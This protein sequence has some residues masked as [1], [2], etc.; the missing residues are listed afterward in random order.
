MILCPNPT[1]GNMGHGLSF[2]QT[3]FSCY[4]HGNI[5]VVRENI[6]ERSIDTIK[7]RERSLT[8]PTLTEGMRK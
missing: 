8:E 6:Y 7:T 4:S 1:L 3:G 2:S 5:R